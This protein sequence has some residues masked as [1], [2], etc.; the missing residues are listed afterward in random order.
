MRRAA[1]LGALFAG[2]LVSACSGAADYLDVPATL[3]VVGSAPAGERL[4][5]LIVLPATG[6]SAADVYA[7]L[8]PHVGLPA[9]VAMLPAGVPARRDYSY[10]FDGYVRRYE[11]RVEKDLEAARARGDIDE[12]SIYVAGFSLG[13]D[14]SWAMLARRPDRFRAALIMSSGCSARFTPAA[15]E[16]L[17]RGGKRVV[18]VVGDGDPR[19]AGLGRAHTTLEDARVAARMCTFH[20]GHQLPDTATLSTAFTELV[21]APSPSSEVRNATKH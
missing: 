6:A 5:L 19:R 13:G 11:R 15:A 8:A 16:V 10:D 14:L 17:R 2:G 12:A 4:P 21:A 1:V 9:Y 20:G 18:F 3:R 7:A